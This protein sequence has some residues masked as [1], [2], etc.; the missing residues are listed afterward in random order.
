[1]LQLFAKLISADVVALV[2]PDTLKLVH[3]APSLKTFSPVATWCT[4][5][6]VSVNTKEWSSAP[7]VASSVTI[8]SLRI[9]AATSCMC[10][11]NKSESFVNTLEA[12]HRRCIAWVAQTLLVPS[13]ACVQQF[14]KWPR[15]W[16]CCTNVV[17]QQ[18]VMHFHQ[19]LHGNLR[20]KTHS[21][22]LKLLTSSMQLQQ[23]RLIWK[24]KCPWTACCAVMLAS[25]KQKLLCVQHLKQ[26]KM[27]NKSRY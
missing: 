14:V 17:S 8:Y 16:C 7:L 15:N 4:R 1:M 6:M 3:L 2:H 10:R 22:L 21:H 26:F 20:W 27:A 19:T 23:S 9:R 13:P 25:V 11:P 12:K 5:I 18:W 24:A